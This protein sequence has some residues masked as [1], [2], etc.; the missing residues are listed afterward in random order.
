MTQR[1]LAE[2]AAIVGPAAVL[3][4]PEQTQAFY[5]DWRGVFRGNAMA[6]V[7]PQSTQEVARVV[8]LAHATRTA[9]VPQGG[10]TG[11]A[12]GA[13]PLGLDGAIVLSLSRMH[14]IESVDPI[15]N[16]LTAQAGCVLTD[17]QAAANVAN[18]L[19][20]LSLGAEGSAQ[21]GGLIS[22]NA[23]GSG[24]LRYGT[25]RALVLG[26]EAVLPDGSI[27]DGLRALRKDNAGY[28]WK[29]LFIGAEGTLGI[30]TSAVLRLFPK[31]RFQTTALLGL[32]NPKDALRAF[33]QLQELLGDTLVACELFSD[34]TVTLRFAQQPSLTRPMPARPW[35]LLLEAAASLQG[36]RDAFEAALGT[37]IDADIAS[38]CV[39]AE[40][41]R[42][43]DELWEWR[44]SI[45]ETEKRAARSAKHDVSVP[46]VD[47]PRFI[48]EAILA[49]ETA[50][51]GTRVLAFGHVGD[52]NVHFNVLLPG[53]DAVRS[54]AVN[55][56]VHAIVTAYRG[57]IT[58]EHGI[59]RYRRDELPT[60]RSPQEMTLMRAVKH[61][62]DPL[63]IMN[64]GSVLTMPPDVGSASEYSPV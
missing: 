64:P 32:S 14:R 18:R 6:V 46:I 15:G 52:G 10:N 21:I 50:H 22:T 8:A 43:S 40:S 4:D 48:E 30:V 17:V 1:L 60:Q 47:V 23:G 42:Q 26:L 59:G 39:V 25:M 38:D 62:I 55:A 28:D 49:V 19:F 16:T 58:A 31:P 51:P 44:E 33:S 29:Q 34:T 3:T 41:Q 57:S 63:G 36:T 13:T 61:A 24:V 5:N 20:P 2:L 11:L 7:R 56:T 53:E 27:V 35:Y 9:I 12:A 45:P 54:D 37:L